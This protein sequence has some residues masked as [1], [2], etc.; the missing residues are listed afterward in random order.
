MVIWLHITLCLMAVTVGVP[1]LT[2][3]ELYSFFSKKKYLQKKWACGPV[4][5]L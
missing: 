4:N 1:D 3:I 5:E 2:I